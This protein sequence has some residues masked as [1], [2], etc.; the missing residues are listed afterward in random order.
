MLI[1]LKHTLILTCI[2]FAWFGCDA[3][4]PMRIELQRQPNPRAF[5]ERLQRY[6]LQSAQGEPIINDGDVQY[7][8]MCLQLLQVFFVWN[9]NTLWHCVRQVRYM[10]VRRIQKFCC[11]SIQVRKSRISMLSLSIFN[12]FCH[13]AFSMT[14]VWQPSIQAAQAYGWS[15]GTV[16]VVIT[17]ALKIAISPPIYHI[18]RQK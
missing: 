3:A 14:R 16:P 8:G 13:V 1:T 4:E 18:Q 17:T 6:N 15:P 5:Q 2:Q 9:S 12:L 11:S 10:S 7:F